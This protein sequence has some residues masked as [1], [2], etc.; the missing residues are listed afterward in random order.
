MHEV[1]F[2]GIDT[3]R[4][5][6]EV[7]AGIAQAEVIVI[8]PSNPIVSVDPI[9]AVPG[10]RAAIE[11]AQARRIPIVAVSGIIGGKAL[12]GPADRMLASLGEEPSASRRGGA[13]RA[14]SQPVRARRR[15]CGARAGDPEARRRDPRHRH[16]HDRRHVTSQAGRRDP[17]NSRR[18]LSA[19][20]DDHAS[21][22][23]H[24][25][26]RL[27]RRARSRGSAR[28]STPR[29][30]ATWRCAW[31]T[32][33]SA[34]LSR[35]Q[36]SRRRSSSP[37]TTRCASSPCGP[38]PVRCGSGVGGLNDGLRQARD[39]AVAGGAVAILVLPIDIPRDLG[40]RC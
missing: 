35:R 17:P 38:A 33:R 23:R 6:P 21:D 36:A 1:R 20:P 25:P 37:P 15:R 8:A 34:P 5:T 3:A 29:S 12:K 14:A 11:E 30:G 10:T 16:D 18:R 9:L 28:S 2:R 19:G 31:P 4:A 40:R 24:R 7:I 26:G 22:R 39:E 27:H 32:A 13:V